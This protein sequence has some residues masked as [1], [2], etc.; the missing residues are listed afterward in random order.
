MLPLRLQP[1]DE[2][3]VIAPSTSL[4]LVKGEQVNIA[5]ERLNDLGFK[6]TFGKHVNE[7]DMFFS[8][9]V[10][11]RIQDLHEAFADPKVKAI[12]TAVGG[13]N[14]NQLLQ[15]I[16]YEFI[17]ANPKILCGL[18]DS[19]ALQTAIYTKTGLITYYGP[20]FSTFGIRHMSDYLVQ[21][22]LTAVTNDAPFDLEPS[23]RWSDDHWYLEQEERE[24]HPHEGYRIIQEGKAE[25]TLIGGNLST[26][27]LL[28][29]T[30]YMPSL[31]RAILFIEED[32][33]AHPLSFDRGLQSLLQQPGAD[34]L[35]GVLI[36]RFQKGS[37]MTR[38]ALDQ[39]VRGKRELEG[40]PVLADVNIGHTDPMATLPIGGKA[41]VYAKGEKVEIFVEQ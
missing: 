30:A 20:H 28:Q 37:N 15:H 19:T 18:G 1:G 3:R 24:F 41:S 10:E 38:E 2:I 14:S 26:L 25:G 4:A 12:V 8:T 27:N 33:E 9:S 23:D 34:K 22:F 16:D 36:G 11:E 7:H 5:T 17:Q 13:Y 39:I 29:G 31:E 35:K 32:E 40:L 21:G 6:V